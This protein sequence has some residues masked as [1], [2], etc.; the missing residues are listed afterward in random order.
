MAQTNVPP[1]A[2]M[3]ATAREMTRNTNQP[4][5]GSDS[6]RGMASPSSQFRCMVPARRRA[7]LRF[8]VAGGWRPLHLRVFGFPRTERPPLL[9]LSLSL[10]SLVHTGGQLR[11]LQ[12]HVA[13]ECVVLPSQHLD[14]LFEVVDPATL[15][16]HGRLDHAQL[17]VAYLAG[18][19]RR[20]LGVFLGRRAPQENDAGVVPAA[21]TQ[22][23]QASD[24][25]KPG[26]RHLL[27]PLAG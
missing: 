16:P 10:E 27:R 8:P 21:S 6:S 11:E 3:N 1:N 12:L 7:R 26:V 25:L 15:C 22:D 19:H 9:A 5:A 4:G 14:G 2:T 23:F 24:A 18:V 20:G 13:D 17:A